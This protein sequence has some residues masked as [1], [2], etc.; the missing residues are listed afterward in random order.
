MGFFPVYPF[1]GFTEGAD[2]L[3]DVLH[4]VKDHTILMMAGVE[5]DRAELTY[6]CQGSIKG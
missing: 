1:I 6:L 3:L 4:K 5:A 2:I